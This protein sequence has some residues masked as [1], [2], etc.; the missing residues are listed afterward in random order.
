MRAK[1][2]LL[3]FVLF[4]IPFISAEGGG[5]S[6]TLIHNCYDSNEFSDEACTYVVGQIYRFEQIPGE[7]EGMKIRFPE[8]PIPKE[9]TGCAEDDA[10]FLG[11]YDGTKWVPITGEVIVSPAGVRIDAWIDSLGDLAIV[12]KVPQTGNWPEGTTCTSLNCGDY[13]AF[14]VNPYIYMTKDGK[15]LPSVNLGAQATFSFC[16]ML[17][18]CHINPN[19]ICEPSEAYCQQGVSLD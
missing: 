3:M 10:I 4:V 17:P 7:G 16:G 2:I 11:K 18:G 13:G 19:N 6:Y 5:I 1:L 8:N 14:I 9:I 12:K 15:S